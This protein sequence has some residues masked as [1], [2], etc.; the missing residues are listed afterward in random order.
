MNTSLKKHHRYIYSVYQWLGVSRFM[1][2]QGPKAN[3]KFE[4]LLAKIFSLK[5]KRKSNTSSYN[6]K[7][8]M[9][10]LQENSL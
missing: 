1:A 6:R 2:P 7:N 10:T 5:Q 3:S 9:F 4:I 8:Q